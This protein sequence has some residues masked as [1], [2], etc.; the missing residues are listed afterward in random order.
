M[1]HRRELALSADFVAEVADDA[2][3]SRRD[4]FFKCRSCETLRAS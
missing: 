1:V 2:G 3:V 4:G